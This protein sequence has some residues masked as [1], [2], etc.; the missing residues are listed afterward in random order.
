VRLQE[1]VYQMEL[2]EHLVRPC[3]AHATQ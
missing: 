2:L 3:P 1:W